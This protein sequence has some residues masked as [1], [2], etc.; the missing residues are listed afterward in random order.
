MMH[1]DGCSRL[2]TMSATKLDYVFIRSFFVE[3]ELSRSWTMDL[4]MNSLLKTKYCIKLGLRQF[5]LCSSHLDQILY[6]KSRLCL[7]GHTVH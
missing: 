4:F 2:F 1:P 3:N 5:P 6:F 7:P